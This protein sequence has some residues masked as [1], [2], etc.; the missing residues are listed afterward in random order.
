MTLLLGPEGVSVSGDVCIIRFL[1]QREERIQKKGGVA[2]HEF[3]VGL[4]E[5]LR[6]DGLLDVPQVRVEDGNQALVY[7]RSGKK[8][9]EST[10]LLF[11]P[12]LKLNH[13]LKPKL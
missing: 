11:Q 5:A 10:G 7:Q 6:P 13:L 12:H 2:L 3:G 4:L 8:R 1:H 9:R